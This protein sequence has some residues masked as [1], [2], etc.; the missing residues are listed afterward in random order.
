MNYGDIVRD[1]RTGKIGTLQFS[2]FGFSVHGLD[3]GEGIRYKTL[4]MTVSEANKNYEVIDLPDG[5]MV[6]DF[7][8]VVKNQ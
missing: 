5:Y 1:K 8:A 4:G 6:D 7:G 2:M 3:I